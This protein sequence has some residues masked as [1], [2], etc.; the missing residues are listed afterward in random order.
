MTS[1]PH[2]DKK[3]VSSGADDAHIEQR[4]EYADDQQNDAA[5]RAEEE[6]NGAG[7]GQVVFR[8]MNAEFL[9]NIETEV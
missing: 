6:R 4:D 9:E 8:F 2:G 5:C 3:C 1:F 7:C